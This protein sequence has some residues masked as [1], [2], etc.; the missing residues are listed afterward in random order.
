MSEFYL[1][2]QSRQLSK[3]V[4][5]G[6]S[7]ELPIV[8]IESGP[9]INDKKRKKKKKKKKKKAWPLYHLFIYG[10]GVRMKYYNGAQK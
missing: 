9:K 6:L 10:D 4:G 5:S 3:K 1:F 8:Y 2:G 7:Y